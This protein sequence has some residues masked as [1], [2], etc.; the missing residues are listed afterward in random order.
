MAVVINEFEVVPQAPA[1]PPA[2]NAKPDAGGGKAEKI[3][4]EELARVLRVAMERLARVR[5]S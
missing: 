3:K 5:A 4:R 2:A 1:P